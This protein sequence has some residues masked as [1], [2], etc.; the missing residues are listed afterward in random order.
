MAV[1]RD[2]WGSKLNL[3]SQGL[4]KNFT[5]KNSLVVAGVS[6]T[7]AQ[8]L[9]KIA[10]VLSLDTN[11]IDT[12][13][14]WSAS[15]AAN[16]AGKPAATKWIAALITAIKSNLGDGSPLLASFGIAA[17]KPKVVRTALEKAVT[18]ALSANTRAVRGTKGAKQRASITT[19]GKPG[20]VVVGV[21]GQPLLSKSVV[22]PG[23]GEPP[24]VL[25]GAA[26][27]QA[28]AASSTPAASSASGSTAVAAAP[29]VSPA[30]STSS[31]GS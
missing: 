6:M 2:A 4:S 9:A 3:L 29:A 18:T 13:N 24:T 12:K 15:V 31:S 5:P 25:V 11:V 16:N 19:A 10:S 7:Q 23:S 27:A 20:V 17:P 30:G 14:A 28:G 8:L 26:A 1:N 21:D 22:P